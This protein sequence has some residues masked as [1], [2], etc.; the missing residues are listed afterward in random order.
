[1]PVFQHPLQ[2]FSLE[3]PEGWEVRYQE[4]TGGVMFVHP[5][6]TDASAVSV[7]P[8]AS[9]GAPPDLKTEIVQAGERVGVPLDEA[10]VRIEEREGTRIAYAEGRRS[11][12]AALGAFRFWLYHHPPVKL[13]VVHLGPGADMEAHRAVADEMLASLTFP[14]VMPPTPEEFRQRVLEIMGR[15]YGDVQ[16]S[17]EGQWA[18]H[19]RDAE[20]QF[21][22]TV[23]L[24]N[25]YRACLLNIETTGMRIREHLDQVLQNRPEVESFYDYSLVRERIL[26]MLKSVDWV[27]DIS[28]ANLLSLEFAQGL[29]MCFVI[30]E[31]T[32]MAYVTEDMLQQWD[33]PLERVQEIAQDNLARRDGEIEVAVLAAEDGGPYGLVLNMQDGYDATRLCIPRIR[34]SFAEELGD[35]FLVGVPNRDF[36][37]AFSDRDPEMVARITAT[38]KHDF[39]QMSHPLTATIYQVTADSIQPTEL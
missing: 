36:L 19:L 38:V 11:E 7:S 26:P 6:D 10:A 18:I 30:D 12:A 20:G 32:R 31:P 23:G 2:L 5:G 22:G 1:M 34:E 13:H 9:I 8:L 37:I 4:E 25:L 33:V 28:D 3:Y 16:T 27:R 21:L 24:E 29:L 17:V 35:S 15:E 14:E 39:H